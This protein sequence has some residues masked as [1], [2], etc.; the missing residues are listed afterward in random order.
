MR[1]IRRLI[2]GDG[3]GREGLAQYEGSEA[4]KLDLD[5]SRKSIPIVDASSIETE[6]SKRLCAPTACL[7]CLKSDQ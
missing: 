2:R 3:D 6:P 4:G 7:N 5:L 1:K